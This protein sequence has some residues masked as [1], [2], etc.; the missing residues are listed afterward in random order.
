MASKNKF[1]YF[2]RHEKKIIIGALLAGTICA[3]SYGMFLYTPLYKSEAKIYIRNLPKQNVITEYGD[4]SSVR[5]ESG[6][7]NPLFNYREIWSSEAMASR[8][9][10]VIQQKYPDDLDKMGITSQAKWYNALG[11]LINT[12]VVPSTDMIAINFQWCNPDTARQVFGIL[13]TEFKNLNLEINRKNDTSDREYLDGQLTKISHDL[14]DTRAQIKDF[15]LHNQAIDLSNE[16]EELTRA[17]V[18]LEQQAEI[19]NSQAAASRSKMHDLA[20]QLGLKNANEALKAAGVGSDPLIVQLNQSLA[21]A[22]EDYAKLHAKYKDDYPAIGESKSRIASLEKSIQD[23]KQ[24][25]LGNSKLSRGL[26]DPASTELVK[27][28]ARAQADNF[29]YHSQLSALQQGVQT[30]KS[31]EQQ[32]P[33][34]QLGLESLQKK[35]RALALGYEQIMTKHMEAT[36]KEKMSVDNI[37]LI[38]EPLPPIFA[39]TSLFIKLMSIMTIISLAGLALAWIK[40]DIADVWLDA[41]EIEGLT[42]QKVLGALPWLKTE[43]GIVGGEKQNYFE[44]PHSIQGIAYANI[45]N[46]LIGRSYAENAQIISFISTAMSRKDSPITSNLVATLAR[47]DKTVILIDTNFENPASLPNALHLKTSKTNDLINLIS[48]VQSSLRLNGHIDEAAVQQAIESAVIPI[49]FNSMDL[50]HPHA[51]AFH[52]LSAIQKTDHIHELLASPAFKYILESLR[53]RYEFI[54]LDGPAKPL[55]YPETQTTAS[56]SDAAVLLSSLRSSRQTMLDGIRLME[57]TQTKILGIVSREQNANLEK[58]VLS[59]NVV[60]MPKAERFWQKISAFLLC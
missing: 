53:K 23:R 41:S 36:L 37:V 1:V 54:I 9:Y 33:L 30:L 52:Y 7:S 38:N 56:I 15:R 25:T 16:S 20:R 40:Y 35:E 39:W 48:G 59:Q 32:L 45:T 17:R 57:K 51:Y 43:D 47:L 6:Y 3:A 5:S 29:S 13:I 22:Q 21:T 19:A 2:L 24:E 55:I 26:Y 28:L 46:S 49:E 34:K 27:D 12:K 44:D 11:N 50:A 60:P 10:K 14:D 42:K 8:T 4:N 31:Q 58:Y 18:Q